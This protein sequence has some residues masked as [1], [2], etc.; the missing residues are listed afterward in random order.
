MPIIA[1]LLAYFVMGFR[2]SELYACVVLAALP[3]GQNV[4][5]YA[6]RYN[7][8][9]TFA[10]DGILMSTMTSP[11]FIAIIAARCR[12]GLR[13]EAF[14]IVPCAQMHRYRTNEHLLIRIFAVISAFLRSICAYE[15]THSC[16]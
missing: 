9:L 14:S 12:D 7:V 15:S 8:G 13:R 1:F 11:V 16:Y 5:N 10:R 3:T 4:Y 2:G 6:A